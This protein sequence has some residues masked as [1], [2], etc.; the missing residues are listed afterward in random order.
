MASNQ[1]SDRVT[2]RDLSRQVDLLADQVGAIDNALTERVADL[3][4]RL[5]ERGDG[6]ASAV[7]DSIGQLDSRL[8][9]LQENVAN[10]NG[11]VSTLIGLDGVAQG[12][13]DLVDLAGAAI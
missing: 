8:V 3:D 12:M 9:P 10:L 1:A 13:A 7:S 4:D 2:V 5:G 11:A 6:M